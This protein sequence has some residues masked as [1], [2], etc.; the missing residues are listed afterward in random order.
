MSIATCDLTDPLS[1]KVPAWIC[2]LE[3]RLCRARTASTHQPA[4]PGREQAYARSAGGNQ[5]RLMSVADAGLTIP[6]KLRC[7]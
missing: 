7:P 4:G 2:T 1:K 6:P 5:S 3:A